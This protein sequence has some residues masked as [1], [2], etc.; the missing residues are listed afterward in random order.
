MI[1]GN[2]FMND[3][4]ITVIAQ[5]DPSGV[6]AI[7]PYID[8]LDIPNGYEA[9]L[10]EVRPDGNVA[11]TYQRAMEASDAKYKIY[12]APGSILLRLNFFEEMLRVFENP[13]IGAMGLVGTKQISTSGELG[14]SPML[15]GRLLYSDDTAFHGAA[16]EGATEEVMAVSGDLIATQYDIPWRSDLFH[17]NCFYAEAQCI[18]FRRR[19]YRSVVP[20][21][22]EAWLLSGT[23]EIS[24]D[25]V[26][27][28]VFLD[29]Y[30]T[31][32]YPLVSIVIPTF[33]RPHYFRLALESVLAQT[34][35]NLDI[36]ITDNSHN[37]ETAEMMR[38]DFSDDPR[39]HYE[40]HPS[41]GAPENWTRAHNYDN[42][43]AAY[44]NW[45]MDDD[46]FMPDKIAVMMDCFFA[47]PDLSLVTSYRECI[48]ADGNKLPDI[49]ATS[50]IAQEITKFSGETIG[51]NILV[52]LTNFVGEPT[53]ALLKK[54]FMLDGHDLGFS[55]KEGK[56]LISDFPTWLRLLSQG[57]MVYFP[58]PLSKFRIHDGNEQRSL[59][60]RI[61]G[62]IC[63]AMVIREAIERDI[64][65]HDSDTR[66]KAIAGWLRMASKFLRIAT[67]IP[68]LCWEDMEFQDLLCVFSGMSEALRKDCRI[69]FDID[70]TVTL[71][72]DEG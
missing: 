61:R 5:C 21:Q 65:L 40:H 43:D 33:E 8:A 10:I 17:S 26:S 3:R 48:D 39:I 14:A 51:A 55:G 72:M 7:R 50:P 23:K 15:K 46:L 58:Q 44:V 49:S 69:D 13:M 35:R 41:Y 29:T 53:T 19:G 20:H 62:T 25:D 59:T 22:D 42:K 47:N 52:Y 70:T 57:N 2:P 71:H 45:L 54:K 6:S 31:D 4:K 16:V 68:D 18:E 67:M 60:S 28:E 34:Y 9:E 37:T 24:Y 64:Y 56:Y 66:R 11:D 27:Q 36:F 12:L 63:W 38:R 30:S 1:E 32:I